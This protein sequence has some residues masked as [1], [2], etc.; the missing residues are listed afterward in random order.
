MSIFI[1]YLLAYWLPTMENTCMATS[2]IC[3]QHNE[4]Y[5]Q[6]LDVFLCFVCDV[7]V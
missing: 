3:K 6:N 7:E 2:E 5:T 1:I 4:L